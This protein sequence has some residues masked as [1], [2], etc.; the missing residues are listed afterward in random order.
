MKEYLINATPIE[1]TIL[2]CDD[3]MEF[4]QVKKI[5]RKY[6]HIIHGNN[7]LK[8]RC[9]RCFAS[10]RKSDGGLFKV[11]NDKDKPDKLEGTPAHCFIYNKSVVGVKCPS[12]LDKNWYI[13][14]T[15]KRLSDYG[16]AI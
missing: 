6:K 7:I 15:K 5:S 8:E 13:K 1:K 12:Y 10:K 11:H 14:E 16:V 2:E 3:L 9:V 4:Q